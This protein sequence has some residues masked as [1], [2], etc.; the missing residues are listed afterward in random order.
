MLFANAWSIHRDEAEYEA[1]EEFMPERWLENRYGTKG[2]ETPEEGRRELYG[3]GAGRRV[4]SGQMMAE[5]SMVSC[6][7]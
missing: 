7:E 5:N 1:P 3:F 4:C 2:Q 6:P